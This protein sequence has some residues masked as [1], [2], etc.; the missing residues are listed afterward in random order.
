MCEYEELAD[1]GN[2]RKFHENIRRLTKGFKT[3]A[4][5][6]RNQGGNLVT[7]VKDILS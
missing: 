2:A 6:C 1:M 4:Y 3:A 7:D 5:S